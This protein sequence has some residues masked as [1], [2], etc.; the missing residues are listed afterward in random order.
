MLND[1]D[2]EI[3]LLRVLESGPKTTTELEDALRKGEE[4]SECMDKVNFILIKLRNEKK[5]EGNFSAE[6]KSMVWNKL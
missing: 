1:K 5:V 6:K 2:I 3:I 4:R